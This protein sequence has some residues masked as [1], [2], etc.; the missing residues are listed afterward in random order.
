M[1]LR[2]PP[3]STKLNFSLMCSLDVRRNYE[4]RNMTINTTPVVT[5][6]ATLKRVET[7]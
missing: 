1:Y 7:C 4:P 3:S 5:L 2:I 6:L